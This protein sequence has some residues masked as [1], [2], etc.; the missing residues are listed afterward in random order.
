MRFA[1][2]L[3]MSSNGIGDVNSTIGVNALSL[4]TSFIN[5]SAVFQEFFVRSMRV[6]WMPVSYSQ[7]LKGGT[8]G[9]NNQSRPIIA[10]AI[11]HG[12]SAYANVLDA[13]VNDEARI[14]STGMP[15]KYRWKNI[16]SPKS[17]VI[18]NPTA[19]AIPTQAWCQTV[20]AAAGAYTGM[21]QFIS[22][23]SVGSLQL[24]ASAGLGQFLVE[25]DVLLR[26]R[27]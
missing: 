14:F 16:E 18:P 25:W 13:T 26:Q 12:S 8:A 10:A 21:L 27:T 22:T 23:A 9:T 4:T 20:S 24:P 1:T 6:T 2:I 17:T 7:V 11:Q 19:S 15:F 5:M 3:I